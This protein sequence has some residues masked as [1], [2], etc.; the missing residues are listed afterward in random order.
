MSQD[1]VLIVNLA[2]RFASIILSPLFGSGNR[3]STKR[4]EG[5]RQIKNIFEDPI[6]VEL[7]TKKLGKTSD[8]EILFEELLL[9]RDLVYIPLKDDAIRIKS[10]KGINYLSN[11]KVLRLHHTD[12]TEITQDFRHL[13]NL[14]EFDFTDGVL[15]KIPESIFEITSLER[16]R[17]RKQKIT[18]LPTDVKHAQNLKILDLSENMLMKLPIEI[19]LIDQV[20]LLNISQNP[21]EKLPN[22]I[23]YMHRLESL[24]IANTGISE[25][26]ITLIKAEAIRV[27]NINGTKITSLDDMYFQQMHHTIKILGDQFMISAR[28]INMLEEAAKASEKEGQFKKV[29]KQSIT[30]AGVI[31]TCVAIIVVNSLKNKSIQ[32]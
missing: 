13:N 24:D 7:I 19:G 26:P 29:F 1:N 21:I 2:S 25:L 3:F 8:T 17:I 23:G 12:I 6:I 11:L 4:F 16:I 10:L 22:E 31:T 32:D 20:K 18:E 9:I 14:I 27:I 5:Y 28:Q 30:I 15:T